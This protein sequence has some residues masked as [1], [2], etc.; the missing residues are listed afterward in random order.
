MVIRKWSRELHAFLVSY[1]TEFIILGEAKWSTTSCLLS[2]SELYCGNHDRRQESL[3][4]VICSQTRVQGFVNISACCTNNI[5]SGW[6][7]VW[8]LMTVVAVYLNEGGSR[9]G[10]RRLR[11][12]RC[13]QC[14][15]SLRLVITARRHLLNIHCWFLWNRKHNWQF[16]LFLFFDNYGLCHSIQGGK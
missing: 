7:S 4:D 8:H 10:Q 9:E 2:V 14:H 5:V 16:F 15:Y 13:R 6:W 12:K 3:N 11:V 1:W